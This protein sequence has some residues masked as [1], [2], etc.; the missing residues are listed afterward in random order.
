M[1][2][3]CVAVVKPENVGPRR[4]AEV[5]PD[6]PVTIGTSEPSRAVFLVP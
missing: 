5:N 6:G 4:E 2:G 1:R 3:T